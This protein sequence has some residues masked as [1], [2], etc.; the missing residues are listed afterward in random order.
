LNAATSV[1]GHVAFDSSVLVEIFSDSELGK[2][3]FAR[4]QDAAVVAC[5]SRVNLAEATYVI[6]RKVG[7]D[8]ALIAAKDLLDSGYIRLEEDIRVHQAAAEIKCHR[9]ISFVDCYTL[10]VAQVT[11]SIPVFAREEIELAREIKTR[12]F[13]NPPVFLS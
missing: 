4:L 2:A 3:L 9:A 10:A 13:E 1:K 5:T 8:K 11:G 12:P 6:C 7:H